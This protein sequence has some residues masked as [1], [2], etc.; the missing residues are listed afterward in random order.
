MPRAIL[1]LRQY[2]IA[3]L[4]AVALF[5]CSLIIA[6]QSLGFIR[7]GGGDDQGSGMGGTGKSG[8]FGDSGFGG[9]GGPVPYLGDSG[10]P[11]TAEENNADTLDWPAPWFPRELETTGIPDDM[12][13][14]IELQRNPPVD[15]FTQPGMPT[16]PENDALR[17]QDLANDDRI[18]PETRR[19]I[20]LANRQN[21]TADEE[22]S[23]E[24]QATIPDIPPVIDVTTES[25]ALHEQPSMVD[26]IDKETA[27]Q[28]PLIDQPLTPNLPE[29]ATSQAT[30]LLDESESQQSSGQPTEELRR[31]TPER[32]NRPELPPFQ[33][34]R[35]AVDRASITPPRPQP[36]RI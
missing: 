19:I 20:E 11:D 2:P 3:L 15:P 6:T 4:I 13:P 29:L 23:L 34:M 22:P 26:S 27:N 31:D 28:E 24:I 25:L 21:S 5:L 10:Q 36:M 1:A 7:G 14:L 18:A 30:D 16:A 12:Q 8:G 35:P 17:I 33:R 32:I 9:T